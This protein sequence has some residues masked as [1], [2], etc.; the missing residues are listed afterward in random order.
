MRNLDRLLE[1]GIPRL[2]RYALVLTRNPI[3]ADDLVQTR[4]RRSSKNILGSLGSNHQHWLF[5]TSACTRAATKP[6]Q[7]AANAPVTPM[8]TDIQRSAP[9]FPNWSQT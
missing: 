5:T 1:G 9:A 3:R 4:L 8:T 6:C 2:R 7:T